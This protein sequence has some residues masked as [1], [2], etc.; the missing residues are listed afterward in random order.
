MPVAAARGM[1]SLRQGDSKAG[2]SSRQRGL[3]PSRGSSS[4][5]RSNRP[6]DLSFLQD[7]TGIPLACDVHRPPFEIGGKTVRAAGNW[8]Q[9]QLS[10]F[11]S[12]SA[13]ANSTA[14]PDFGH[15]IR[16][17]ISQRQ[18]PLLD[19]TDRP[20]IGSGPIV[21]GNETSRGRVV[22]RNWER[23]VEALASG[24]PAEWI[25]FILLV[26]T[27]VTAIWVLTRYR[28]SLR[29]DTDPA[30]DD[31]LFVRHVRELRNS[32]AVTEAEYRSL[33]GRL[34]PMKDETSH[35]TAGRDRDNQRPEN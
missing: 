33:K 24:T 10:P 21:A 13:Q 17:M 31:A 35:G 11:A 6:F 2:K 7:R 14:I 20:I 25:V 3:P 34:A 29:G 4:T 32:G 8:P 18:S 23:I 22:N 16:E 5:V 28:S 30:V 15:G 12:V 27:I 1:C 9:R 19:R 26:V